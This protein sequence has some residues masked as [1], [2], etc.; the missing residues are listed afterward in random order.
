MCPNIEVMCMVK[1]QYAMLALSYDHFLV[2]LLF[3][4][5]PIIVIVPSIPTF[6]FIF[7]CFYLTCIAPFFLLTFVL[8]VFL[9]K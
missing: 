1:F 6:N 7:E 9:V 3:L 8:K 5:V 4:D 2:L